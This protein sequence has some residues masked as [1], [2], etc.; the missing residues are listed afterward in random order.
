[1]LLFNGTASAQPACA[2]P[3][4]NNGNGKV[5]FNFRNNNTY[6]VI[7]TD[8]S[9]VIGSGGS[10]ISVATEAWWRPGAL[11]FGSAAAF[12]ALNSTNWTQFGSATI[13]GVANTSTTTPQSFFNGSLSLLVPAGQTIGVAINAANAATPTTGVLRYSTLT[14]GQSYV[15][16]SGG[17][18]ILSGGA[19]T[20]NASAAGS[21]RLS[22]ATF[23]N[24]PRG[25]I[26]CVTF[27]QAAP[28]SGTPDPGVAVS[29]TATACPGANFTLSATGLSTGM[30]L[31]YQWEYSTNG[32]QTW[33]VLSGAAS[34]ST[35][36]S[37]SVPTDYR[38]VTTCSNSGLSNYS[39]VVSVGVDPGG[40]T[41]GCYS[42]SGI[43]S[44]TADED[45]SNV[46]IGGFSNSSTC[47]S[48]GT[49]PGSLLNR[50]S[51]YT[52]LGNGPNEGQGAVVNFSLTMTTCGTVPYGHFFQIYVDWNQDGDWLDAGEQVYSE[53]ASVSATTRTLTGSFVVPVAAP[54]GNTRMRVVVIET[55]ASTVNYAHTGYTYG[56]TED[57]CFTVGPPPACLAPQA[58][59]VTGITSSSANINFTGS[60]TAAYYEVVVQAPGSGAPTGT[61]NIVTATTFPATGLSPNTPYEAYARAICGSS[62]SVWVGPVNFRTTCVTASMPYLMD[63]N[64]WPP[65]CWDLTGGTFSATQGNN[66]TG[67]PDHMR[68]NFWSQLSGSFALATSLPININADARARFNWS[69]QYNTFYPNDQVLLLGKIVGSTTWDT[70]VNLFGPNFNTV[71]SGTTTPSPVAN[72]ALETAILPLTYT[73][74]DVIFQFR[75]NSGFGPDIFIDNFRVEA[76]PQCAE[77]A[78]FVSSNIGPFDAQFDWTAIASAL[79]YE[80][81]IQP[82]GSG[83]PSGTGVAAATNTYSASGLSAQTNY[84]AYVRSVCASG[85]LSPWAGPLA[86]TTACAFEPAPTSPQTFA[87]WTGTPLPNCW[88][89]ASGPL[90]ATVTLTPNSGNWLA[91]TNFGNGTG[92]NRAAKVNLWSTQNSW[93]ISQAIDLGS[94]P[95]VYRLKYNMAVTSYF[96]TLPQTTLGTHVVDVVVSTDAGAT[97]SNANIIKTYTGAGNYSNTGQI[98]F[99]NLGNYSGIIKVAFVA[100]TSSS[101]PDIDFHIDDVSVEAI[102]QCPYPNALNAAPASASSANLNWTAGGTETEWEA[103][104]VLAGSPAP[105]SG[106]SVL[107]T[108]FTATGLTVG[109]TYTAYV[110]SVCNP[111][112]ISAWTTVNFTMN[113]CA[114]AATSTFDTRIASVSING[115]T[116]TSPVGPGNCASYTD[117]TALPPFQ[118]NSGASFPVAVQH[119][120]CGGSYNAYAKVYI[121]VNND[122]AFDPITEMVAQGPV[123]AATT[124]SV[125]GNLPI[126]TFSGITRLRVVLVETTVG[127]SVLPCGPYT[128]GETQDFSVN[129]LA[130]Q[131]NDLGVV[132]VL[133]PNN[134]CGLG[135]SETVTVRITNFGTATQS[136]FPV[137]YSVN[138]G[139]AVTEIFNGSIDFGLS[140]NHT[141]AARANLSV[142]GAYSIKGYSGLTGDATASNDTTVRVVNNIPVISGA[143]LPYNE[144]FENGA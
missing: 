134:G 124:L 78:G 14:A 89:K 43:A 63:F 42:L 50:Y 24:A 30:G 59:N 37:H 115:V 39:S 133:S 136:N 81:V 1:M 34:S 60:S 84:E 27:M 93:L 108:S 75:L 110:R 125:T 92:T 26:G 16:S 15:Y 142:S 140:A 22:S 98:E 9:S 83:L 5:T 102:P 54:Q 103:A 3:T 36:L 33:T 119:G 58:L 118:I 128:W 66:S 46:T 111:T 64:L 48:T 123:P 135:S 40:C 104:V 68:A 32:G 13:T 127:T 8:I 101:T 52:N 25:F 97:W 138:G 18:D 82:A 45:I 112:T 107:S 109:S 141:F 85:L 21:P 69:H 53:P 131:P 72:F 31:T 95:G 70:L 113:Y 88:E 94:V 120:T 56:E 71:G 12:P 11:S 61:G 51:N 74:Q 91:S 100:T 90:G 62:S 79:S 20:A 117:Y 41:S 10:G 7:I 86:F 126:G 106:T 87:S 73:G 114:S 80:I 4:N 132:A 38:L 44:S 55:T 23:A 130:P 137:S 67:T 116:V 99:V 77:P 139:A 122:L 76:I 57:Y 17:C 96:G 28:C 129:I 144:N 2:T 29:S 47:A 35:S 105:T 6:D 143:T 121:D 65:D 19:T 49:G